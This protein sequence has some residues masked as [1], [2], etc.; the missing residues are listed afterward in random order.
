MR[1]SRAIN[2]YA[3]HS[4]IRNEFRKPRRFVSTDLLQLSYF[5]ADELKKVCEGTKSL[6]VVEDNWLNRKK[7]KNKR[8]VEKNAESGHRLWLSMRER[9]LDE[10]N[11]PPKGDELERVR[12]ASRLASLRDFYYRRN[13]HISHDRSKLDTEAV[14]IVFAPS[15]LSDIKRET[16]AK[17]QERKAQPRKVSLHTIKRVGGEMTVLRVHGLRPRLKGFKRHLKALDTDLS[18]LSPQKQRKRL[19]QLEIN[20]RILIRRQEQ[21]QTLHNWQH[22]RRHR[23]KPAPLRLMTL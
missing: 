8:D 13:P 22:A 5:Y 4:T 17:S 7:R 23:V 12:S 11:Y 10:F 1:H 2:R 6:E 20:R 9:R 16:N 15:W 3:I 18:V 21:L 14:D 19:L